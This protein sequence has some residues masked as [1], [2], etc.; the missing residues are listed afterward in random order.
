M[1]GPK[2]ELLQLAVF[3]ELHALFPSVQVHIELVGPA[4]PESRSVICFIII[5]LSILV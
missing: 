5:F 4:I 2:K 1:L 3:G